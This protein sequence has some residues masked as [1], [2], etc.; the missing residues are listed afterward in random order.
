MSIPADEAGLRRRSR[1]SNV[2]ATQTRERE[3]S[4]QRFY[5]TIL[6]A[7]HHDGALQEKPL[8]TEPFKS[9]VRASARLLRVC[10]PQPTDSLDRRLTRVEL[11]TEELALV[12]TRLREG[13][14]AEMELIRRDLREHPDNP[15]EPTPEEWVAV[16]TRVRTDYKSLFL[17]GDILLSET[18]QLSELLWDP[19]SDIGHADGLT[20]FRRQVS[21]LRPFGEDTSFALCM[22]RLFKPLRALDFRLGLHRDLFIVHVHPDLLASRQG[23]LDHPERFEYGYVRPE[24]TDEQHT[25]LSTRVVETAVAAGLTLGP[26]DHPLEALEELQ[27]RLAAI[28]DD[29]AIPG[30]RTLLKQY[31]GYMPR[32]AWIAE[33][34]ASVT[35][36]WLHTLADIADEKTANTG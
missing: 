16:E 33:E 35:S 4:D 12:W 24:L 36:E 32:A 34:L 6:R 2:R 23:S 1:V 31:G 29:T 28:D 26:W 7:P 21:D 11:L 17:L 8:P 27:L 25:D 22:R 19:P 3:R 13:R 15:L 20:R 5:E 9:V 10:Q 14:L 18:L 30:I